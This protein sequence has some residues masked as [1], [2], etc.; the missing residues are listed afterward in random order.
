MSATAV[1][2]IVGARVACAEGIKDSWREVASWAASQ[3]KRRFGQAVQ[4]AY[5]D[6]FDTHCPSL[7]PGAR[8]PLVLINGKVLSSGAKI[9]VPLIRKHLETLGLSPD[10]H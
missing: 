3:L 9:S 5:Y 6:L 2:Q 1:I 10:G 4:L 8:L 7:P